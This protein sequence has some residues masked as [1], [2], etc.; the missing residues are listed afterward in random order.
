M[1]KKH[2]TLDG[3]RN[4]LDALRMMCAE[5]Y[6][7]LSWIGRCE[8]MEAS[9]LPATARQL[10][11]HANHMTPTLRA[12]FG[13]SAT[14]QVLDS[15]QEGD[16]Y[17][18]RILLTLDEGKSII[19]FGIVSMDLGCVDPSTRQAIVDRTAPLGDLLQK[20]GR[21]TRVE[22]KWFVRFPAGGPIVECFG[23]RGKV[24]AYGRLA[25][26][27]LDHK[28]AVELLEVVAV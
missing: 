21:M 23:A 12:H 26:I 7:D 22:P 17:R 15:H 8:A 27:H 13:R 11:A 6:P 4:A 28:P 14:L 1:T 18:R 2:D 9:R 10:L 5:F 20:E 19:E 24:D 25:I 3:C 16:D